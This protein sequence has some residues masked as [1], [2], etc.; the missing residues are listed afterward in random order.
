MKILMAASEATPYAK[1]GGLADVI[2]AL[3]FSLKARREDVAVALPLYPSAAPFLIHAER[4]YSRM[5]I[6]LGST[7]WECEIKKVVERDVPFFFVD[8]PSLFNRTGLYGDADGDYPDNDIRF[9]RFFAHA[10]LGIV[11]STISARRIALS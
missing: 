11:R 5:P 4:V 10:V 2:G 1:T 7:T 6:V 8:C 9:R 3:P